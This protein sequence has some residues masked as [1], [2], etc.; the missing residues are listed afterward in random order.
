VGL[1][2]A[3]GECE[4]SQQT[5]LLPA[6]WGAS[7]LPFEGWQN[8]AV[9]VGILAAGWRIGGA[10]VVRTVRGAGEGEPQDWGA[11]SLHCLR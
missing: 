4:L 6:G 5:Y 3:S 9:A 2:W 8:S 1:L 11:S 10:A 7:S